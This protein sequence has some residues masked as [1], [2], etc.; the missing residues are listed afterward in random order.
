MPFYFK[1]MTALELE[2]LDDLH[3]EAVDMEPEP[4]C[5]ECTARH[6]DLVNGLC[7]TCRCPLCGSPVNQDG[8]LRDFGKC[9]DYTC[10]ALLIS[11]DPRKVWEV[12]SYSD[13]EKCLDPKCLNAVEPGS[14]TEY[15]QACED[16]I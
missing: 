8:L 7:P 15:C 6:E 4:E 3:E 1:T 13:A 2:R 16:S 10:G 9:T 11:P 12:V 5:L 14:R